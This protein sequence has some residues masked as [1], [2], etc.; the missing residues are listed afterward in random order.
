MLEMNSDSPQKAQKAQKSLIWLLRLL[1]FLM[2]SACSPPSPR[3]QFSTASTPQAKPAEA[4]SD[5]KLQQVATEALGEREGTVLVVDPQTGRLRAVVNPRLAFEQAYPPGSAI[6]PFTALAAL[7]ARLLEVETR[8]QCQTRYAREGFE[9]ICSHPR[10]NVPFNLS[11]ALAYSCNDYFA[12]VGERLSEGTFNATLSGFGFG[13][14]TGVAAVE[15]AGKLPR[16]D[17]RVQSALGDDDQFLVTPVQ[18]LMAFVALVNG[19]ELFRP[20]QTS[21][22]A[23]TPIRLARINISPAHRKPLIEGM[24][25]AVNYGTAE[26]AELGKLPGYVFGKTGTSTASNGFRTQGWFVGFAADKPATGVPAP[27]QIKLGVLVFLK[28]AHGS[29]AASVA[30]SIFE[31]ALLG[32]RDSGTEGQGDGRE[33]E[34]AASLHPSISPSLFPQRVK[35]RSISENITR[36]LPLEEYLAGALAGEASIENEMEALKAQAVI[37]RTFAVRNMGRHAR[38]GFDFCSATHCQRFVLP[39]ARL[40]AKARQA[41]DA[42]RGEILLDRNNQPADVYFHA[43]CGGVTANLE[44]LWGGEAP[45]YLRGVKDDF[46]AS[47]PHRN[48]TQTIS[49]TQ[50]IKALQSDEKTNAGSPLKNVTVSKRD[51]TGR[52]EEIT[53]EAT[54]RLTVRG[55]D[56][57]LIVGRALG[58]HMVKSSRFSITRDGDNFVFRGSGFGHGLG[59]CQEGAHVMAARR[60]N[61]RQIVS[62]YF[63]GA[64]LNGAQSARLPTPNQLSINHWPLAIGRLEKAVFTEPIMANGQWLMANLSVADELAN[65]R[66]RISFGEKNDRR[67][68]EAVLKILEAARNDLLGRLKTA[69][70]RLDESAPFEIV[71]HSTTAEFIAATGL[72]GWAT[73]ATRGRRIELQPLAL[74][75]KRGAMTTALRHELAHAAIELLGKGKSPR[76]LAEGLCLHFAGEA[77]SMARVR[78]KQP[79]SREELERRF[80]VGA[81]MEETR[82][83][84]ALAWREVQM[85]IREKDEAHVWQLVAKSNLT[86]TDI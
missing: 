70:L 39:K 73:G 22:E 14:R 61:Y 15:A 38:E 60:M 55:W 83:L 56:F 81:S 33:L 34:K 16:G 40:H 4:I 28:R 32:Q 17:W 2:A 67:D 30:R 63:P 62:F 13:E 72:S 59:L 31:A 36:E 10:S 19:G 18:L 20:Q 7:R 71:I 47:M 3:S 76:W 1:C 49:S 29:Q 75:K 65:K 54:R 11:Q 21:D 74:L 77:T 53:I 80:N 64:R 46:C 50:L 5:D 41:V 43:A 44:T 24:R 6:K 84:Y 86:K 82:Q 35:V 25:G 66:F 69:S 51:A 23:L 12:H 57:K 48:W 42:T 26:K 85:L 68:V 9:I 58:W 45:F 79:L 37:S 52:A 8:R 27:Q 78:I